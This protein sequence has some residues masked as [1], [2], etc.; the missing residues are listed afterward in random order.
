MENTENTQ[1]KKNLKAKYASWPKYW[2]CFIWFF[3]REFVKLGFL[4]GKEGFL[5]NFF[6][7]FWYRVLADVKVDEIYKACGKDKDAIRMYV[8]EHYGLKI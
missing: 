5:W 1:K 7:G 4:D 6:Q 8:F 3:Y 2:R